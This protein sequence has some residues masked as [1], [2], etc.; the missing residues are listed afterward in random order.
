MATDADTYY[1]ATQTLVDDLLNTK[2]HYSDWVH[3]N[4]GTS[5]R[6]PIYIYFTLL[7]LLQLVSLFIALN[8]RCSNAFKKVE[9]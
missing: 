9:L 8:G 5:T 4:A 6:K 3:P 1:L 7:K 2:N